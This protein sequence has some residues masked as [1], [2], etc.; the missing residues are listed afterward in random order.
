MI[1]LL[2]QNWWLLLVRGVFAVAFAIFIYVFLPFVPAPLL[3]QLAFAGVA[4]S[5]S[6]FAIV[7]GT[8]TIVAAIRGAGKGE[9]AWLLLADGITVASGGLIIMLSPGLTLTHVIQLIAL[10]ALLVGLLEI[11]A[12][13]HLRR[14]LADEW[15]LISAGLISIAFAVCLL[16]TPKAD[17]HIVLIWIALYSCA[18]GLAMT[19]LA[20]RLRKLRESIHALAGSG[21]AAQAKGQSGAG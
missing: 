12:G 7:T 2:I 4:A 15:L 20:F 9:A 8:V 17:R 13:V 6:L 14:H 16:L 3:R 21:A 5:F 10:I 19:R 11:A 1:R 18:S